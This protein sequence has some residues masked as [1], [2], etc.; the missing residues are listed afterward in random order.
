[1][2]RLSTLFSLTAALA[3]AACASA[4]PP[5]GMSVTS[6]ACVTDPEQ[7]PYG[8]EDVPDY[9]DSYSYGTGYPAYPVLI[10]Y[11]PNPIVVPTP[12]TPVKPPPP[13]PPPSKPH[14]RTPPAPPCPK[15]SKIC[16]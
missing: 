13:A 3:V 2:V 7:N 5:T 6:G 1:M 16:P 11:N 12:P 14:V 10:P 9:S 15:G 8:C 4:P